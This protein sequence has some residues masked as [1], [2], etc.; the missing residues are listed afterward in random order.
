MSPS[1]APLPRRSAAS[2]EAR[3]GSAPVLVAAWCRSVGM[4]WTLELR[5]LAHGQPAGRPV[6]WIASGVPTWQPVPDGSAEDLL[7][8]RGLLL[9]RDPPGSGGDDPAAREPV[10]RVIGHV[11]DDPA[12]VRLARILAEVTGASPVHPLALAVQWIAAGFSADAAAGW[13]RAGVV[14]PQVAGTLIDTELDTHRWD[15]QRRLRRRDMARQL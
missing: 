13:V 3:A 5:P 7:A 1:L 11:T 8:G 15:G 6:D 9:L 10:R 12:A 2:G 14:W 4:S